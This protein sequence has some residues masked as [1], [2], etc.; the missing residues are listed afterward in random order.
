MMNSIRETGTGRNDPYQV[1][2]E[3]YAIPEM[4]EGRGE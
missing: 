4:A 2:L 3:R 1:M